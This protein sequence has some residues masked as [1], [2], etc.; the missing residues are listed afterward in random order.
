MTFDSLR[1]VRNILLRT[2]VISVVFNYTAL[3]VTYVFWDVWAGLIAQWFHLTPDA[4]SRS[5]M[6]YF[7]VSVKFCVIFG[8][9][10]PALAL[11]WTLKREMARTAS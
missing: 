11:H 2:V 3:I 5:V 6:L 9:L 10:A 8:L 4:L 1:L 7:F